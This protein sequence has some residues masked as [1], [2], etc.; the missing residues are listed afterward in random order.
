MSK[1]TKEQ[2]KEKYGNI[3]VSFLHYNNF[4]FTFCGSDEKDNISISLS[5]AGSP[6]YIRCFDFGNEDYFLIKD[7][8]F[9]EASIIDFNSDFNNEVDQNGD[10]VENYYNFE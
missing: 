1:L 4:T 7:L 6:E 5:V 2:F 8:N 9:Y 10:P 3:Q